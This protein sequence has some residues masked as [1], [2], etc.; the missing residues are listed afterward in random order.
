MTEVVEPG[1]NWPLG[2]SWTGGGVNFALHSGSAEAVE[3]CLFAED[4]RT[5]TAR[6][7]L[8]HRTNQTW[9]GHVP[10]IGPG[11]RYGYRVHGPYEPAHGLRFNPAKLLLDPYAK[12]WDR[13]LLW[14]D[15]ALGHQVGAIDCEPVFDPRD[16]GPD[17]AK[18]LV[19][20]PE[21]FDWGDDSPP[22]TPLADTV[23]YELHVKGFTQLHPAV[24]EA[25]RGRFL[26][27]AEPAA[28]GHLRRLGVSAVELLPVMAFIDEPLIRARGLTNYWGYNT[29]GFFVP[30]ARYGVADAGR[31]LKVLV[32]RLH[33]AGLEV[34]L[35]V[36]FNHT[37]EGDPAG[38]TLSFRGIDNPGY[39]RLRPGDPGRYDNP[40][41][42][43]NALNL[44]S[45]AV[46]RLVMDSLRWW[47]T[48]YRVDGFRFD[49]ATVLARRSDGTFDPGGPFLSAISQDPVLQPLKL[50]A[51]PWDIGPGGYRVGGFPCRWSE[52][53]D[54][55][56]DDLRRFF[57]TRDIG[58]AGLADRL[59]GS[60]GS[61]RHDGRAPQASVNFVTAHD[62][63][64]LADL[65]TYGAKRN[66][67]NGEANRDGA[68]ENW[69]WNAGVEGP[70]DDPAVRARRQAL[71]RVLLAALL[72]SR[73]VP[74]LAMG[75]ELGRSQGGNNNA[76][77][78]DNA[79]SWL[80]WTAADEGLIDFVARL[81]RLRHGQAVP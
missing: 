12:A 61:F 45:P 44:D 21:A 71:K 8:A 20:A 33:T 49:L 56:R 66:E 65:V 29:L 17:M 72:V 59:A 46:L 78:Q 55:S 10:G 42:T 1:Q 22:A 79:T 35:D 19:T 50:I 16:N 23:I 48:E 26:G 52:W 81:I 7:A 14:A 25:L 2:S 60:S 54:R 53:N 9:H 39:Y 4:G 58:P 57:L 6:I 41:G 13:P 62:G 28:I 73:G 68:G 70:S 11:Q 47:A 37:A 5:E 67:A 64:T 36:V 18:A 75:D 77:C 15:P 69:G 74:M 24:P 31:E 51:E 34:I 80:D 76:W 40:T 30:D 38:P 43:G 27:L 3:V 32:K 63:F